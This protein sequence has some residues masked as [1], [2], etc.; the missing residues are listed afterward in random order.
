MSLTDCV[1]SCSFGDVPAGVDAD[2]DFWDRQPQATLGLVANNAKPGYWMN[3]FKNK[4][5]QLARIC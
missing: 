5:I 3:N 2:E 1:C 4:F